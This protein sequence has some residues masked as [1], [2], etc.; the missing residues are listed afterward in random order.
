VAHPPLEA[1]DPA[2]LDEFPE[3]QAASATLP[4]TAP[5]AAARTRP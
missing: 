2:A 5:A 1:L 3:E 4:A